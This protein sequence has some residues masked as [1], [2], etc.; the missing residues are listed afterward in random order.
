MSQLF[1]AF[2]SPLDVF[3]VN[4][5][6][7]RKGSLAGSQTRKAHY[8]YIIMANCRWENCVVW[9]WEQCIT[10]T[11]FVSQCRPLGPSMA[12]MWV[13]PTRHLSTTAAYWYACVFLFRFEVF[14]EERLGIGKHFIEEN[15]LGETIWYMFLKKFYGEPA[16]TI[17]R[18]LHCCSYATER[19]R[20][21][22]AGYSERHG[23]D[24]HQQQRR[25]MWCEV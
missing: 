5:R 20:D 7:K 11:V 22:R 21:L 13:S 17:G 19:G 16:T 9:I 18:W 3:L 25:G 8:V 4:G 14:W 1:Y 12:Y 2:C 10:S 6:P 23:F 24:I 15:D